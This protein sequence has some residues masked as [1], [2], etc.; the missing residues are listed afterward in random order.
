MRRKSGMSSSPK[1]RAVVVLESVRISHTATRPLTAFTR[2]SASLS[3]EFSWTYK[4]FRSLQL[5]VKNFW[6]K[7]Q[8]EGLYYLN[9]TGLGK[10][11]EYIPPSFSKKFIW[12]NAK[13]QCRASSYRHIRITQL[14]EILWCNI[15]STFSVCWLEICWNKVFQGINS[16]YLLRRLNNKSKTS[17]LK[18]NHIS[19]KKLDLYLRIWMSQVLIKCVKQTSLCFIW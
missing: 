16:S 10:F 19:S 8:L 12:Q 7:R 1:C 2:A 18:N 13:S 5:T 6:E 11:R 3:S 4:S 9:F 15:T 17:G 14:L